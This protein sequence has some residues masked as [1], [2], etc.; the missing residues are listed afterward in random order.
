[1]T[2]CNERLGAIKLGHTKRPE[3][4]IVLNQN[5]TSKTE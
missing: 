1:M 2:I 3:V 5:T 4:V